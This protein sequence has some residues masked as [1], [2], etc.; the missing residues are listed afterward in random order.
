MEWLT[1][2]VMEKRGQHVI[3]MTHNGEFKRVKITGRTPDIGEEVRVP[4]FRR[5][6]FGM[7]RVN[8]LAIA[9][10]VILILAASPLLTVFNQPSEIA[11]AYVAIDINPSIELTV[12]NRDNVMDAHAYNQDGQRIL[13]RVQWKG[14]KVKRVVAAITEEAVGL[15]FIKKNSDNKVLISVAS[16][17]AAQIDKKSLER[18]LLASANEVLAVSEIKGDIQTIHV[19]SDMRETANKKGLSP[20]KYAVLIEAVNAGL[21]VTENDLKEQSIVA[22]ISNAGGL[23]DVIIDQATRE[24]QFEV[25]ERKYLASVRKPIGEENTEEHV[26]RAEPPGKPDDEPDKVQYIQQPVRRKT[27]P[28]DRRTPTHDTAETGTRLN[29][30]GDNNQTG[31]AV[32]PDSSN[33]GGGNNGNNTAGDNTA[34][35]NGTTGDSYMGEDNPQNGKGNEGMYILKPN[36]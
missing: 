9:A 4:V 32:N 33:A 21:P 18:T 20:G 12:S 14:S 24:D 25:K 5:R 19:P 2:V 10:A 35:D 31:S 29:P 34:G 36:F 13:D 3:L 22:A 7:P 23:P 11:V 15:G 17:P 16:L 8:W 1:G 30:A 28:E 27:G 6:V 26:Y